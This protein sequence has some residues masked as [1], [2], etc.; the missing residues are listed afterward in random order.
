MDPCKQK[1]KSFLFNINTWAIHSNTNVTEFISD[2]QGK[3][4]KTLLCNEIV[5]NPLVKDP[6]PSFIVITS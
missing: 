1:D 6:P 4:K 2:K 3:K 5:L